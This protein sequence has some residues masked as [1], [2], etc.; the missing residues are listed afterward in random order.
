MYSPLK[1]LFTCAALLMSAAFGQSLSLTK[2]DRQYRIN[3]SAPA[4]NPG[5]LQATEDFRL[6]VDVTNQVS[7]PMSLLLNYANVSSRFFRLIPASAEA[8]P[9]RIIALGDSL[10]TDDMGWGGGVYGYLKPNATFINWAYPGDSSVT[11]IR[12][13]LNTMSTVRPQYVFFEFGATDMAQG[14]T[15]QQFE[16]NL[17]TIVNG[18]RGFDGVPI[19]VT[20][21]CLRVFDAS[22][23][24]VPWDLP[25]NAITRRV[26]A[27]MNVTLIDLSKMLGELYSRLGPSGSEFMKFIDPRFPNDTTHFS[28]MG[29]VWVSQMILKTLPSLGPYLNPTILDPPPNPNP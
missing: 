20:V 19:L 18:V 7:D 21:N 3:A 22:G 8:S 1:A 16:A 2:V 29:A 5:A 28:P 9:I 24:F 6:W 14:V 17:K 11:T 27:E 13:H 10:I 23:N 12:F 26:A 15:E 4:E 25:Y